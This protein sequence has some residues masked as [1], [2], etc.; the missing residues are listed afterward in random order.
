VARRWSW[1][2]KTRECQAELAIVEDGELYPASMLPVRVAHDGTVYVRC[3]AL[4]RSGRL[5]GR[6]RGWTVTGR[7]PEATTTSTMLAG[8]RSH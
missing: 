8:S 6:E 2:C 5:C 1:Q 7:R 3:M 4:L